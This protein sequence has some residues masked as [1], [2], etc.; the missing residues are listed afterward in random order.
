MSFTTP[1]TA[2]QAPLRLR[3]D[4]DIH[5]A[6][7]IIA[8]EAATDPGHVR[9]RL[10]D[11]SQRAGITEAQLAGTIIDLRRLHDTE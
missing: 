2:E 3:D 7:A 8:T 10:R 1:Q 4:I 5:A 11:A 9:A 6:S